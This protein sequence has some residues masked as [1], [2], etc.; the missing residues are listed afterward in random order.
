[1]KITSRHFVVVFFKPQNESF[2]KVFRLFHCSTANGGDVSC[3][4]QY[5]LGDE[6]RCGSYCSPPL[7]SRYNWKEFQMAHCVNE[8]SQFTPM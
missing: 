1:M 8:I 7:A 2:T 4:R 3:L 5:S 6:S